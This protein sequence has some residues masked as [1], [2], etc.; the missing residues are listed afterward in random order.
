M[1][2]PKPAPKASSPMRQGRVMTEHRLVLYTQSVHSSYTP[3]WARAA[4]LPQACFCPFTSLPPLPS[5]TLSLALCLG[6]QY[7]FQVLNVGTTCDPTLPLPQLSGL[8][9]P[10]V[11]CRHLW[12]PRMLLERPLSSLGALQRAASHFL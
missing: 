3:T 12:P 10:W 9:V 5:S 7:E 1:I 2:Y 8:G 11:L 4:Q 6:F